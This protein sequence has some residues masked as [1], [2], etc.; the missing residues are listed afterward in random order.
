MDLYSDLPML[1]GQFRPF[2]P[3]PH[4]G[5]KRRPWPACRGGVIY[6]ANACKKRSRKYTVAVGCR[7]VTLPSGHS[8]RN[9]A[10]ILP[11]KAEKNR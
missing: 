3:T 9:M 7:P 4:Y 10:G 1:A 11:E 6:R 8:G 2:P 5:R